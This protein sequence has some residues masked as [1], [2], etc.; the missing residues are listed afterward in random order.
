MHLNH[1]LLNELGYRV[2]AASSP[3]EALSM[4]EKC[5]GGGNLDL[6]LT[7]V[8]MPE[9]KVTNIAEIL[10]VSYPEMK[11]LFMSGYAANVFTPHG[12]LDSEDNFIAKP[13]SG[14]AL[15]ENIREMLNN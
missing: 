14:S 2:L 8:V 7:D 15:T 1:E 9:M 3:K 11:V 5:G 6:L 4:A 12:V 13:F 10:L